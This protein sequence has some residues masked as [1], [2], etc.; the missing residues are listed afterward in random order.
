MND[1]ATELNRGVLY[2]AAGKKYIKAAILSA[3][4]VH[5]KSPKLKIALF[6]DWQQNGFSRETDLA[7]FDYVESI[8]NPHRRSK[9]DIMGKTPFDET[10]YLDTDTRIVEDIEPM[11][12]V[13]QRFDLALCHAHR[14]K[15]PITNKVW[16]IQFPSSYPQFNSG[17]VLYTKNEKTMLFFEQW[18]TNFYAAGYPQDQITLRETLWNSALRVYTLPPEYN[19]R[20]W[21][22]LYLWGRNEVTPRILH[23]QKFHDGNLWFLKNWAKGTALFF[24]R[25]FGLWKK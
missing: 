23:M 10:L 8:D 1:I 4:T 5:E 3:Q 20:F 24:L 11:F 12:D 7:I 15:H 18:K 2:I 25:A 9:V 16:R 22:Y 19:V 6:A 14:R 21:K 13:L 17:V